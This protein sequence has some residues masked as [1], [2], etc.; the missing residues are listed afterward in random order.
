M[1]IV[2]EV[3][4]EHSKAMCDRVVSYVGKSP[5]RFDELV[6]AFLKGP[7][8]VTQRA[9]WPL[10]YCVEHH[11]E[12]IKPYL[13]KII[14]NLKNHGI[15][16][17]VKRNTIRMLQFIRIPAALQG[18][19]ATNCFEYLNNPKEPVAVRVFS[20]SVLAAIAGEQP[21]LRKE[22]RIIIEDQMPYG[23]P[24]FISRARAIL[25]ELKG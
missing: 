2:Q 16:D 9:A 15:H 5:G 8:R 7:Y 10:S 18:A 25:K 11:P 1:N 14:N 22:L 6:N 4:R 23:S 13:R 12:L 24:G 3:L 20:M 21:K 19:A 17:S